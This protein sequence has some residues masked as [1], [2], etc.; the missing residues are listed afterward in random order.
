[1]M[2]GAAIGGVLGHV[3]PGATPGVWALL[4]L[5]GA[6]GGVTRPRSPPSSS[7]SN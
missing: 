2:L 6:I 5:A 1:M 4:G 7:P 3:L